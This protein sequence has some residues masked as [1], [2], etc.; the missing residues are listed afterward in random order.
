[1]LNIIIYKGRR[2]AGEKFLGIPYENHLKTLKIDILYVILG[3]Q[4]DTLAP[5]FLVLGGRAL[6]PCPPP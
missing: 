5:T 3:G 1:M 2:A 4:N 6:A